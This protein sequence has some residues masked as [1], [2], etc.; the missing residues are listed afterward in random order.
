MEC[1][2]VCPASNA[3]QISLPP[4]SAVSNDAP[5]EANASRWRRRALKPQTVAAVLAL[6]F[7]GLIGVARATGHW[8][9]YISRYVYMQ[10][11]PDAE[12]YD[13]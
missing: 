6:L 9:T 3:L 4:R 1:I 5:A 10:L 11:V 8:Q 2:A 13:H 12:N 7:L